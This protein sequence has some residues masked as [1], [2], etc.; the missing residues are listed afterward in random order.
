MLPKR[1]REEIESIRTMLGDLS[2]KV[3][4]NT[5]RTM[6]AISRGDKDQTAQAIRSE[7]EINKMEVKLEEA[8]LKVMTL[9]Q[10]VADEMRFLVSTVK[11]N[12][13]LE[14]IGDLAVGAAKHLHL[15]T[16]R[17]TAIIREDFERVKQLVRDNLADA[18]GSF[19]EPDQKKAVEIWLADDRIDALT[20]RMISKLRSAIIRAPEDHP[21][22]FAL[23][24]IIHRVERLADHVA[25]IAKNTIYLEQGRVVRHR[26]GEFRKTMADSKPTVLLICVHN[27]ARSQMAA[28]WLNHL[29]GH[30]VHAESAGIQPGVLNPLAVDV[31][32][33][34]GIDISGCGTRDVFDVYKSGHPFTHVIRVCDALSAEKC[35]PFLDITEEIDWD[36][37]DPAAFEGGP[38]AKLEYFRQVRD[39]IR[40]RV[41]A[42]I[43]ARFGASAQ[44]PGKV[45]QD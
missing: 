45:I 9:H 24:A 42:W 41:D 17:A 35:P 25:N 19:F 23:I 29:Y 7:H 30:L 34:V 26:L 27:S 15:L 36:I 5:V 28:A 11:I 4:E 18:L 3:I 40:R 22:C 8:C 14:R 10:P 31:M 13:D 37:P 43:E 39:E 1:Y 21:A 32:K 33:E 44:E 16:D 6:E 2:Q 38:E 12:H 20:G